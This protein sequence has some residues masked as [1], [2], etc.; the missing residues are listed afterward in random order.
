MLYKPLLFS[1]NTRI[2]IGF[3]LKKKILKCC[4]ER[5]NVL[6]LLKSKKEKKSI[7][8]FISHLRTY[9]W[10]FSLKKKKKKSQHEKCRAAAGLSAFQGTRSGVL[11]WTR[12]S[13]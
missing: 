5:Q 3:A 6:R 1:D 13:D 7:N 9:K 2:G 8:L 10:C 4:A 12:A 11:A